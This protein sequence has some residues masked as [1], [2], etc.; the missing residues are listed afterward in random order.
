[1]AERS[2][3]EKSDN[4]NFITL[5]TPSERLNNLSDWELEDFADTLR[6]FCPS[7][8]CYLCPLYTGPALSFDL[9]PCLGVQADILLQR[10]RNTD[11]TR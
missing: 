11:C 5:K 6:H 9:S 3:T 4:L 2:D 8:E 1:M 10:R 7:C